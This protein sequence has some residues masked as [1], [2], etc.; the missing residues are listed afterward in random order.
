MDLYYYAMKIFLF[1]SMV[2]SFVKFEPLQKYSLF[3]S[4]LYTSLVGFLSYVFLISPSPPPS[5][6][7]WQVWLAVNFLLTW[8]YFGLLAK[9]DGSILFW[10][11]L[12]CGIPLIFN[13]LNVPVGL[14]PILNVV[15]NSIAFSK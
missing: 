12:L 11:V 6:T 8:A 2:S 14:G 7:L 9:F 13:E 1:A 4:I 5:L 3:L 15:C 10:V